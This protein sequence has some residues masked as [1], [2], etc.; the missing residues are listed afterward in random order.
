MTKTLIKVT[1]MSVKFEITRKNL[2][3]KNFKIIKTINNQNVLK[4]NKKLITALLS[5]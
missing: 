2:K 4:F 5:N 3:D 1:T